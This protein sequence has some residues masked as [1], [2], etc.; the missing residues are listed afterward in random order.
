VVLMRA[1]ELRF[2]GALAELRATAL[3]AKA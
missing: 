1:G 3:E 2:D